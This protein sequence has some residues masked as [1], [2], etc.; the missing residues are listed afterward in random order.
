MS[1]SKEMYVRKN[2]IQISIRKEAKANLLSKVI[3]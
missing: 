2:A 1:E 3:F